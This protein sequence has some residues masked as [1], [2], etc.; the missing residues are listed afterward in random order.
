MRSPIIE[1]DGKA[2]VLDL[3]KGAQLCGLPIAGLDVDKLSDLI[4]RTMA[5]AG[6]AFAFGRWAE[7]RELYNNEH[8]ASED[9]AETRTVH[10]G[11]DL[12]CVTETPV[13]A[14]LDGVV[15]ILSNNVGAL[16]YGPLVVL[17]HADGKGG[18]FYT[19]YG[20]LS[21][22][23]LEQIAIGQQVAAGEPIGWVGEPPT[24][25]NWPPHLHFQVVNDLLGLGKDFPG[26]ALASAKDYWLELSPS[27][28]KYFPEISPERLE[29]I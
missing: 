28:A 21:L 12:F 14:P 3:S 27:P 20:H 15:S 24:N 29:Y 19:L 26:V 1:T 25:G 18:S 17:E 23:T 6:T 2:I 7:P 11:V 4:E 13:Y 10:M 5:E 9:S 22:D 16:D 8:F